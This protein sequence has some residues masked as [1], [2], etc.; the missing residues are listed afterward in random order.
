MQLLDKGFKLIQPSKKNKSLSKS[1]KII[2]HIG[3]YRDFSTLYRPGNQFYFEGIKMIPSLSGILNLIE[4]KSIVQRERK[5]ED[6]IL[7]G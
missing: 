4:E 6:V 3:Q 5:P 7:L 2:C 1:S